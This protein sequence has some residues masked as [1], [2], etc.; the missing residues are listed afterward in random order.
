[1]RPPPR[2]FIPEELRSEDRVHQNLQ[3]MA[4]GGIAVEID[5]AGFF[6]DAAEFDE[7]RGHHGEI[8]HHVG[9]VEVGLE[10]AEGI[11]H[12]ASLLDDL[13]QSALGVD[14]PLPGVLEGVNLGAGLGTVLLGEENV[15]VLAGVEGRVEVDEVHRLVLYISL[16]DFEIVAVIELVF[17]GRHGIGMRLTQRTAGMKGWLRFVDSQVS[18][19]RAGA[20]GSVK[21]W[22]RFTNHEDSCSIKVDRLPQ[23]E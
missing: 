8:G 1:M 4:G 18:E 20:S 14:V 2:D 7:A 6:E 17:L 13:L 19:S 15:I 23:L 11:G 22:H 16:E 12:A 21:R 9:A 3:V 5:G 10:G